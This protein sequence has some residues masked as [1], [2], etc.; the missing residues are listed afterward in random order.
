M[1]IELG[2]PGPGDIITLEGA[3]ARAINSWDA[4]LIENGSQQKSS[5]PV[6][7]DQEDGEE[8]Y[9]AKDNWFKRNMLVEH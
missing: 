6:R 4:L 8:F 1:W 5:C 7:F 2:G 9:Q 3:L